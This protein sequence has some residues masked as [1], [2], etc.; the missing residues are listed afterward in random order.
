MQAFNLDGSTKFGWSSN[1]P[2]EANEGRGAL[3]LCVSDLQWETTLGGMTADIL[4][5][6]FIF[7]AIECALKTVTMS[8]TLSANT[9]GFTGH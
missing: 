1:Y 8:V 2:V 6:L 3:R 5:R 9:Q 4:T 7:I